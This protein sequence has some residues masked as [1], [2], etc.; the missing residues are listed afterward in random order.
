MTDQ[1]TTVAEA[2]LAAAIDQLA[3]G[4]DPV[5]AAGRIEEIVVTSTREHIVSGRRGIVGLKAI[6]DYLIA[7]PYR[8]MGKGGRPSKTVSADS[9][10]TLAERGISDRRTAKRALDVARVD[11]AIYREYIATPAPSEK[12]LHRFVA[13]RDENYSESETEKVVP[14]DK[15]WRVAVGF[16][17]PHWVATLGTEEWYTPPLIFQAM[18][19]RFDLDVA[20]PGKRICPWIP[21]DRHFTIRENG[22]ERDW[23][24]AFVWMNHPYSPEMTALWIEKFRRHGNGIALISDRT[25]I[26]WAGLVR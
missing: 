12:G 10:P 21:A 3:K 7:N 2:A 14:L 26:W 11:D 15:G 8:G 16:R 22:L 17:R 5:G 20:S 24:D 6:G 9:L 19:C 23:G 1:L 25:S 13:E 4:I 18:G